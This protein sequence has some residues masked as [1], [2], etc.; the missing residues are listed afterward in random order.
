MHPQ[1]RELWPQ[2]ATAASPDK[3]LD[4]FKQID[5]SGR[6]LLALLNDLLDLAKL[7]S[8]K[9]AFDFQPTDLNPL[10]A[11]IA[12]EFHSRFSERQLQVVCHTLPEPATVRLDCSKMLQALR[13]LLGNVV[14]F[15][16]PHCVIEL[17]IEQ[18]EQ[19]VV[20][21]VSDQGVG[22]PAGE[23]GAIFNRFIPSS[24]TKTGAGGAGL[25]IC[26]EMIGAHQGLNCA[27]HRP[28]GGVVF[29]PEL[30]SHHSPAV[31]RTDEDSPA[32]SHEE[33]AF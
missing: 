7:E 31:P 14:K 1:L 6:I 5:A 4:Y 9:M 30:P 24:E 12:D 3:L 29:C 17:G 27:E 10:L 28:G 11:A 21:T 26:R 25:A 20:V 18:R 2:E 19:N 22:I 16:P 33:A 8:G 13:N 23:E 32:S 15:S